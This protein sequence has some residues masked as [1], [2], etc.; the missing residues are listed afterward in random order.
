MQ[1]AVLFY[2]ATQS[3][4]DRLPGTQEP[5]E[6]NKLVDPIDGGVQSLRQSQ[7]TS[8]RT[9]STGLPEAT[10]IAPRSEDHIK[11]WIFHTHDTVADRARA[12]NNAVEQLMAKYYQPAHYS[13]GY[14]WESER[15]EAIDGL[16]KLSQAWCDLAELRL[17]DFSYD[18]DD[19]DSTDLI[20][21]LD[22]QRE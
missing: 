4:A 18:K 3:N 22:M 14:W 20:T 2:H 10:R 17:A 7:K 8:Q 15:M 12:T 13:D 11:R 9:T 5:M 16:V 21:Y 1:L 19:N 6:S